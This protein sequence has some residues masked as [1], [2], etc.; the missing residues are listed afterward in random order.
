[1]PNA[2]FCFVFFNFA[3]SPPKLGWHC[4]QNKTVSVLSEDI[5]LMTVPGTERTALAAEQEHDPFW[6]T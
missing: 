4:R 6:E 1:M 3:E 5:L 2:V